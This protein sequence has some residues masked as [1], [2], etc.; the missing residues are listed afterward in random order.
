MFCLAV[1]F[2]SYCYFHLCMSLLLL[3]GLHSVFHVPPSFCGWIKRGG[4]WIIKQHITTPHLPL[5]TG[6]FQSSSGNFMQ[7]MTSSIFIMFRLSLKTI[8][9]KKKGFWHSS[10]ACMRQTGNQF[11][12]DG[13][14]CVIVSQ[15]EAPAIWAL[16]VTRIWIFSHIK[17]TVSGHS[18]CLYI[19]EAWYVLGEVCRTLTSCHVLN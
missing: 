2:L 4:N 8:S 15:H 5:S 13:T 12:C 7:P 17:P 3:L 9:H 16:G 18:H 6:F 11:Q 1:H 14:S 19:S 10:E